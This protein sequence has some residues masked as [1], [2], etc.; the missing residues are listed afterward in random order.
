MAD[1]LFVAV[2]GLLTLLLFRWAFRHLPREKWQFMAVVPICKN[3][4]N[5]WQGINLTYY[6]FFNATAYT[7]AGALVVV[8]TT[9]I[10]IPVGYT[11]LVLVI[12]LGICMP[13]SR[14]IARI[15][16]KKP[17][18]FSIGGAFFIGVLITPPVVILTRPLAEQI[19]QTAV[20]PMA[21]LSAAAIAYCWGEGIGRLACISFGCCYGKP[22]TAVHPLLR[23]LF[24][25]WHFTFLGG[26]RKIAYA[27][28][29]EGVQVVP[30]QGITAVL[31]SL[32]ALVSIYA[33]LNDA[34]R[35]ALLLSLIVSQLWRFASEFM[36]ADYRGNG[37]ISAY[38]V[39]SLLAVLA[40]IGLAFLPAP[41]PSG[42]TSSILK[43]LSAL[44]HPAILLFLQVLWMAAFIYTG[45]SDVTTATIHFS[46]RRHQT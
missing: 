43:G 38:Q 22:L 2:C 31:Y 39:M 32:T 42:D 12:I 45:R 8:L 40:A 7:L 33:F 30:V 15:V 21:F 26:T 24:R 25:R 5:H 13:S 41:S 27:H 16:E 17:H 4:D 19:F 37:R 35:T 34:F 14:L 6:G 20:N 3:A 18:T 28:R 44:W 29:L 1:E 46:V 11:L 9:A 36:R 10:A 23:A